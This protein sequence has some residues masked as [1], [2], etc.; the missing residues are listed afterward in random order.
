[1]DF[2]ALID[3]IVR[4]TTVLIAQLA[5][6]AGIRA[7]LAHVANQVFLDL[8]RELEAQGL[9]RKVVADMFGIALRSY[10]RKVQRIAESQTERNRTLWTATIDFIQAEGPVSRARVMQR[11]SRDDV[12]VLKAVLRD[13]VDN[14]LVYRTGRGESTVYRAASPEDIGEA[15][16]GDDAASAAAFVHVAVYHH[17]PVDLDRLVEETRLPPAT[18]GAALTTLVAE[19]RI[20]ALPPAPDGIQRWRCSTC[21]LPTGSTAGWEAALF[22]HYQA[23]VIAICAKLQAGKTRSLPKDQVGGSTY[24]YLVW[25]GHPC[26]EAVLGQLKDTRERAS[27]LRAE[28]TAHNDAHGRP[29]DAARVTFYVGQSAMFS[30]DSQ[31]EESPS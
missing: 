30:E 8:V 12:D 21:L 17:G 23:M 6:T 27:A 9:G 1:M 29:D 15:T 31:D 3:A 14:G 18:V 16:R 19:G 24:E 2:A 10:Q 13:L 20:D 5:T 11:F 25:P 26:E 28:V 7:P 4:Q 22:H